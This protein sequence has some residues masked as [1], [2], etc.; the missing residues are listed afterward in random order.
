MYPSRLG[1]G[2]EIPKISK[3]CSLRGLLSL[4]DDP[5]DD[6]LSDDELKLVV[7]Q[8]DQTGCSIAGHAACTFH[9]A[10]VIPA[11]K[12]GVKSIEQG[13]CLDEEVPQRKKKGAISSCKSPQSGIPAT[14]PSI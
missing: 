11:L 10:G 14:N 6:E 1:D 5:D 7:H 13:C 9:K 8:S 12:I 3:V 2:P 4:D